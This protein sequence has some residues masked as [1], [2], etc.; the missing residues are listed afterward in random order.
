MTQPVLDI[1]NLCVNYQTPKGTVQALRHIHLQVP[2]AKVVG[3]V[4]ESG[5]GKST[6][7]SAVIRLMAENAQVA[8]GKIRFMG[9]DMQG[10][11]ASEL[12]GIRGRDI[13]MVFQ[14]P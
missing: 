6:L 11:S 12:R 1:S 10:F 7:I 9:L 14:I 2:P 13:S 4:G 5:C 3:L 8:A